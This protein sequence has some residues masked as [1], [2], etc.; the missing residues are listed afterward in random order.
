[1]KTSIWMVTDTTP[2]KSSPNCPVLSFFDISCHPN[3]SAL[4]SHLYGDFK[5]PPSLLGSWR[6]SC[7]PLGLDHT[8]VI[9]TDF[10][11]LSVHLQFMACENYMLL[12]YSLVAKNKG[13]RTVVWPLL[14]FVFSPPVLE[15]MISFSF[16]V[17]LFICR[18]VDLF[19]H[20]T[21]ATWE[22]TM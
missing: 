22:I 5:F 3:P 17:S 9:T 12:M 19:T 6:L 13:S 16:F 21:N 14:C 1:M 20:S 11:F 2:W 10:Y 15:F 7:Y 18:F 8:L 4:S